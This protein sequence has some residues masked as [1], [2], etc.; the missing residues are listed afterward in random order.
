MLRPNDKKNSLALLTGRPSSVVGTDAVVRPVDLGVEEE[1][2][3]EEEG[4]GEGEKKQARHLLDRNERK[5][6]WDTPDASNARDS[7]MVRLDDNLSPS[8]SPRIELIGSS[9]NDSRPSLLCLSIN[10]DWCLVGSARCRP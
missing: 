1:E 6:W 4:E 5:L 8:L 7:S 10:V 2:K 9:R 3:E